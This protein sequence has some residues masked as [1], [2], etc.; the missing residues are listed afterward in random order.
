[1]NYNT[2]M[3]G[4]TMKMRKK[5]QPEKVLIRENEPMG[6]LPSVR[7][8]K[9]TGNY[10]FVTEQLDIEVKAH[11]VKQALLGLKKLLVI[12]NENEERRK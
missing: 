3:D 2:N 11:D 10:D 5:R 12:I 9:V 6:E 8:Q 1:M 7:V 4:Y